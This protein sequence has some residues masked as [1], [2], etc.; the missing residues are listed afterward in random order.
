MKTNEQGI[1]ATS[2]IPRHSGNIGRETAR[3]GRYFIWDVPIT[4]NAL[5][6]L[7]ED[8]IFLARE[9]FFQDVVLLFQNCNVSVFL[10]RSSRTWMK[11]TISGQVTTPPNIA[12]N[13]FL[14]KKQPIVST[15]KNVYR[16][17]LGRILP[18][19]KNQPRES[20]LGPPFY[21]LKNH[22][23]FLAYIEK[24]IDNVFSNGQ[25]PTNLGHS[26]TL[27]AFPTG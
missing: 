23:Y 25:K 21:Q 27:I 1:C 18:S 3:A 14:Y 6:F 11:S 8:L 17:L 7:T 19:A 4:D 12:G 22:N 16:N 15:R 26:L 2:S 20:P 5:A 9:L 13:K 24:Y 10:R